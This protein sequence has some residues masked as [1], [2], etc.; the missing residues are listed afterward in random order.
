MQASP[1]GGSGFFAIS[2][3]SEL[4]LTRDLLKRS[5]LPELR[6]IFFGRFASFRAFFHVFAISASPAWPFPLQ[7]HSLHRVVRHRA[8]CASILSPRWDFSPP[9]VWRQHGI[10][11]PALGG[12]ADRLLI[13]IGPVRKERTTTD[14]LKNSD[15]NAYDECSTGSFGWPLPSMVPRLGNLPVSPL[16]FAWRRGSP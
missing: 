15:S 14:I 16:S 3:T 5:V 6:L 9:A 8:A 11:S 2:I 1:L 10:L 4:T 12:Q 13:H 7:Y